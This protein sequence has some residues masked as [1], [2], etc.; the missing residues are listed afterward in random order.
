VSNHFLDEWQLYI[1]FWPLLLLLTLH[2]IDGIV[3]D[4]HIVKFV[5]GQLRINKMIGNAFDKSRRHV[6]TAFSDQCRITP[7]DDKVL[8]E[9]LN[10]RGVLAFS[11]E[12]HFFIFFPSV[13]SMASMKSI[14]FTE[15]LFPMLETRQGA[16]DDP[17]SGLVL[18][19]KGLSSAGW[20][21]T[22]TTHSMMS[23]M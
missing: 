16:G 1:K 18:L 19:H 15:L 21:I 7:M 14:S 9:S 5:K 3:D 23:S 12:Q 6:A 8:A 13:C 11:G 2:F 20:P 10:G 22:R 17:G 4:L